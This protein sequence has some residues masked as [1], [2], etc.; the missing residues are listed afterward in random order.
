M[1]HF[2]WP[3]SFLILPLPW[4]V[5][6]LLPA[7]KKGGDAILHIPPGSGLHLPYSATIAGKKSSLSTL[8]VANLVWILL[9]G[10]AGHPQWL[11]DP[12][13]LPV[14]GRDLLLAVDLSGSME[15]KDF[16]LNAKMVDRLTAIKYVAGEFIQR[17]KGDRLG[18]ILFGRNAYLQA[19]LTFDRKTVQT[20]LDESVI[21]LAG[22]ETAIGNAIGLAIKKF[23]YNPEEKI[24]Q[25]NIPNET[26]KTIKTIKKNAER[27]LILLTDGA[28][29]AGQIS[30]LKAAQLA[31]DKHLKIYTIGIGADEMI[32][33]SIYGNRQ[34]NPSADLDEKTLTT[35]AKLT[36]GQYFRARDTVA[37]EH[38]Y[39]LLDQLE[40]I[41]G[42]PLFFRPS[43]ALFFWPLGL[44]LLL[45]YWLIWQHTGMGKWPA[46]SS[47]RI[48]P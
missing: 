14:S 11:G 41:Q 35:I 30:P 44:G 4:L 26:I 47:T 38:I 12:V 34:V 2:D 22:K 29:T 23:Q 42:D 21:G 25:Y 48:Q 27:V 24:G 13:S 6:Y 3:W 16:K 36:G 31:A 15:V 37:L 46:N 7:I 20:F 10:A 9:V 8:L 19:P 32:V 45:G 28:N 43:K 1:I 5:H 39:Q 18:L 40:P 33:R 17:R